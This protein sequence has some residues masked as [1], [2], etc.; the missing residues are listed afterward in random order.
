MLIRNRRVRALGRNLPGLSS[1]H[2]TLTRWYL[3]RR[4]VGRLDYPGAPLRI[5][6]NSAET[7]RMRM[8]PLA[9]EPWTVAWIEENLRDGDVLYDIGAN[10]GDYALIAGAIRSTARVVAI[11]PG[12][13]NFASL[14]D[15]VQL[16][17]LAERVIP[18]PV[19]LGESSRLGALSYGDLQ[20][21]AAIHVLDG[22][23]GAY[24]Q[25]VLVYALDDLLDRFDLPVPTLMKLDVDGAEAAV[26]A[27]AARTLADPRLRSL[28]IEIESDRSDE[29]LARVAESGLELESRVDER[30]GEPLPG[31]WYGIFERTEAR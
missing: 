4:G 9:K 20:A 3:L 14:C 28:L 16:N 24:D 22:H 26:L 1:I 29:V 7:I 8:R 2:R 12:A 18:L 31:V 23:G 5:R 30:Y 13:A 15:N 6:T 10:V 27:G 19:V 17:H 25:P 11:E 21:G